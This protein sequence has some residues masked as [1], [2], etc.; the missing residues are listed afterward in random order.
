[1][2]RLGVTP[3]FARTVLI[4]LLNFTS[5]CFLANMLGTAIH[6]TSIVLIEQ[7]SIFKPRRK[8]GMGNR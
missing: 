4:W 8:G 6:N 2:I 5:N 1:V 3:F 7:L